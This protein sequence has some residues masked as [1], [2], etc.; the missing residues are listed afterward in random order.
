ML[1][2]PFFV[3]V[4]LIAMSSAAAARVLVVTN[5]HVAYIH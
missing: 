5:R 4:L 2:V 1:L 3:G